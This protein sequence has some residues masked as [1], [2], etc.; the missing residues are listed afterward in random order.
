MVERAKRTKRDG[1][2]IH[3]IVID[4][5]TEK[6]YLDLYK[7]KNSL[8]NF[9]VDP[10]LC[11][12]RTLKE[13]FQT[14][15]ENLN[16]YLS[17]I[18]V[19]DFDVILKETCETPKG[20]KTKISEFRE[21]MELLKKHENVH[22]LI[23][24]PC[25]EYWYLLHIKNTSKYYT[26][27]NDLEKEFKNTILDGYEKTEKFYKQ[28]NKDI[29]TKLQPFLEKAIT[30]AKQLGDINIYDMEKGKAEIY[31]LFSILNKK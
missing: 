23:N 20:E 22:I 1:K 12:K 15:E 5:K 13:Q 28:K 24:V 27:Y 17:I 14:I 6:W 10:E 31:K 8:K 18:W 2:Q 16:N 26:C 9:K 11:K 25:L 30:N 29:Y 7:E 21:Y 3:L 19:I 4:G